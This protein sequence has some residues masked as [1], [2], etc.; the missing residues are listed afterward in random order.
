MSD[1][2]KMLEK[3]Y[4]KVNIFLKITGYKEGYH[5][6]S[7]R[8]M[9]VESLHDLM[10]FEP[11]AGEFDIVGD[12]DCELEQNTIYKAY[13]ALIHH[14]PKKEIIAFAKAHKV[15]VYK[16]IPAYAGLGGGSSNAATFLKM[17]NKAVDLGLSNEELMKV[18]MDVG[19]DVPFFLSDCKSANVSGFG[20]IIEPFD[21]EPLPLKLK[22]PEAIQC[23]TVGVYKTF[24]KYF[25][26]TMEANAKAAKELET[27]KSRDILAKYQPEFLNDLFPAALKLCPDLYEYKG[28][29]WFFSGSGSTF[30]KVDE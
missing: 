22:T 3:A 25:A 2:K 26:D 8:F 28:E 9:L 24:R 6:I 10:W 21:E 11:S 27:M 1:V 5:L 15:V 18:G 23:S 4:A 17:M 30:F 29:S 19:A 12:F 14:Y 13:K 20:E 16:N 7:S